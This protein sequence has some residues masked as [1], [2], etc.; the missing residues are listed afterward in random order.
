[1]LS[2]KKF[3]LCL[4]L[5]TILGFILRFYQY[6][7]IP[8]FLETADEVMYP[9]AG[10]SLLKTGTPSSWS[11]FPSYK[12]AH[13]IQLWGASFNIVTPWIEKPPLYPL[14][15]GSLSLM[16]G[17]DQFS[18]VQIST[19]RITPLVISIFSI[20]LVGL[21]T[22]VIFDNNIAI[23]A[24]LIYATAPTIVIS[25]RLSLTENLLT[26]LI[27]L[28]L[29]ILNLKK[30]K[31]WQK[32]SPYLLGIISGLAILTRQFGVVLPIYLIIILLT[33]KQL[34]DA[35]VVGIFSVI[36]GG[37]YPLIGYYY[38]WQLFLSVLRDYK[39]YYLYGLPLGITNIFR[40]PMITNTFSPFLDGTILAGYILLTAS[41]FIYRN[42]IKNLQFYSFPFLYLVMLSILESGHFTFGWHLYPLFPFA[43]IILANIFREIWRKPE[44]TEVIFLFLVIGFSSLHFLTSLSPF[45]QMYWQ[46]IA[47]LSFLT[48]TLLFI[49]KEKKYLMVSLKTF[50]V[51]YILVNIL[52]VINFSQLYPSK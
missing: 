30:E 27:L 31:F 12:N 29:L 36:I 24:S 35:L 41:P 52:A 28:A 32:I 42:N 25:N 49:L 37:I 8:P 48:I 5:V 11:W 20:I 47:A 14:I 2:T 33:K 1:M 43:V 10:I 26:P 3:L 23:L 46:V 13:L 9:W 15:T 51:L 18:K 39:G 22:A 34:K 6:D 38:D 50:F 16:F 21:T 7:K 17:E 44:V 4:S 45:L 19:I 40:Y